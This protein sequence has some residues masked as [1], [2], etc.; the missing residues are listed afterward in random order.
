MHKMYNNFLKF[1]SIYCSVTTRKWIDLKCLSKGKNTVNA[2]KNKQTK[3]HTPVDGKSLKAN[4]A[5]ICA[6]PEST[7]EKLFG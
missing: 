2:V 3:K 5:L 7:P 4:Q 6:L 1:W